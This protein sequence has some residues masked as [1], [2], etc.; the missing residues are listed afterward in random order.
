MPTL[1]D[2]QIKYQRMS[3]Q[4]QNYLALLIQQPFPKLRILNF[5]NF[6]NHSE[7]FLT[8]KQTTQTLTNLIYPI[9]Q[10]KSWKFEFIVFGI[11]CWIRWAV[12]YFSRN[13]KLHY[14]WHF[15]VSLG[16]PLSSWEPV[17]WNLSTTGVLSPADWT[18]ARGRQN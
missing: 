14:F 7:W 10:N 17:Q 4:G 13:L 11:R 12:G 9:G 1:A 2:Y 6:F 3:Y 18:M 5:H 8:R 16:P 15:G